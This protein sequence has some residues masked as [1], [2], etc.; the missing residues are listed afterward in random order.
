MRTAP[1]WRI[2]AFVAQSL[3]EELMAVALAEARKG[4]AANELPIGAVVELAGEVVAAAH[5]R[6]GEQPRLVDH[7]ELVALRA[8]EAAR[9]LGQGDRARSTL[10]TTLEP[11]LLCMGA[12]MS[13]LAGRVVFALEAPLDGASEVADVWQ[14]RLGHPDDGFPYRLPEIVGGVGRAESLALLQEFLQRNPDAEWARAF[15]PAAG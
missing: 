11:C 7:A 14:P 15:V 4:L 13:F 3:D 10:Y 5:W 12:A 9:P 8:A 1:V 6:I 2:L